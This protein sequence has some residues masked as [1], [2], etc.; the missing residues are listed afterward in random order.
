MNK[1][2]T[3]PRDLVRLIGVMAIG[4]AAAWILQVTG[5]GGSSSFCRLVWVVSAAAIAGA[6]TGLL[7]TS[8]LFGDARASAKASSRI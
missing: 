6:G 3:G 5:A 2:M 1:G 4:V 7:Y 8:T